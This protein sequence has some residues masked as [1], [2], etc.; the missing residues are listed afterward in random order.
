M[1]GERDM[2]K[3]GRKKKY[4]DKD[5]IKR[6]RNYENM[7]NEKKKSKKSKKTKESK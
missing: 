3:K 6:T 5:L 2:K 7:E 1:K 4:T